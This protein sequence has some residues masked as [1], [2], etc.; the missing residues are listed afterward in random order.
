MLIPSFPLNLPTSF[1]FQPL[2]GDL[3][4]ICLF[5]CRSIPHPAPSPPLWATWGATSCSWF[6]SGKHRRQKSRRETEPVH[7][8]PLSLVD[9][10][11]E[12]ASA[13]WPQ[14]CGFRSPTPIRVRVIPASTGDPRSSL[15]P[16]TLGLAAASCNFLALWLL[17]LI[18]F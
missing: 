10:L 4:I 16:L 11:L 13:L 3:Q 7:F 15:H 5:A 14:L 2:W 9:K 8:S 17:F 6:S 12:V 1:S 18:L